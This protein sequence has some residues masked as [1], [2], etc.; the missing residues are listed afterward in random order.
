MQTILHSINGISGSMTHLAISPLAY[1]AIY[2]ILANR[3][4]GTVSTKGQTFQSTHGTFLLQSLRRIIAQGDFRSL[5]Q[6]RLVIDEI[7]PPCDT[8]QRRAKHRLRVMGSKAY[9]LTTPM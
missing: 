3:P 7:L 8:G 6:Q 4:V 1:Y 9:G 2:D 5:F